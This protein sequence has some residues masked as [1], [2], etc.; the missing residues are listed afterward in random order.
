MYKANRIYRRPT[1]VVKLV[2]SK[3]KRGLTDSLINL[4][5]C[6]ISGYSGELGGV[7]MEEGQ[8]S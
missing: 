1:I 8:P 7:Y 5:K 4:F 6:R 2:Q 3:I